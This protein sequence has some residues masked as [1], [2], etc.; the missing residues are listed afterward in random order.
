M[1][2]VRDAFSNRIGVP[3]VAVAV[4]PFF[5]AVAGAAEEAP[6]EGEM[7]RRAES[8]RMT[9]DG[10]A[11]RLVE[12]PLLRYSDPARDTTDGTVWAWGRDGRPA[13]LMGLFVEPNPEAKTPV[14]AEKW[15]FEFVSLTD[16]PLR[17]T[18]HREWTW[19]PAKSALATVPLQDGEAPGD[20]EKRRG[21]QLR[22][23]ARRFT[24]VEQFHDQT[25]NLRL[26][27]RP[28][29]RYTAP[30][31]GLI[32]GAMFA[33]VHG[34]NP[35]AVLAVEAVQTAG[36]PRWRY[37]FV[38]MATA[39]LT[40]SLDGREVWKAEPHPAWNESDPYCSFFGPDPPAIEN[41]RIG[42]ASEARRDRP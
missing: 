6:S 33:F 22:Q 10:A 29:V 31:S 13:A 3:F 23:I 9:A 18:S 7:R 8:L 30:E 27:D 40:A 26:L 32:D 1:T 41:N 5:L 14:E 37:G 19:R 39:R 17:V 35:E 4:L 15:S 21:L 36:G 24:V 16:A 42:A 12:E 38:R 25:M 34:T 11:V 28:L 20:V 2:K